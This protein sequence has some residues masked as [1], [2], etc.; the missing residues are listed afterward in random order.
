MGKTA[1][2][3]AFLCHLATNGNAGPFLIIVPTSVLNNWEREMEMWLED[4]ALD[5]ELYHGSQKERG[6]LREDIGRTLRKNKRPLAI[7]TTY[8]V[9]TGTPDDRKFVRKLKPS[10]LVLDEGHNVK[11]SESSRFQH[12]NK[13]S[14]KFRLLLTGTPLQN[15]LQ[16]LM[17]LLAFIMPKQFGDEETMASIQQLFKGDELTME[18]RI[19]RAQRM[20]S[21]FVLRRM[22]RDVLKDLPTKTRETLSVD[23]TN[24]QNKIYE[25]HLI[26]VLRP[27]DQE[28]KMAHNYLM[29]LRKAALHPLLFR[30]LYTTD[31]LA[32]MVKDMMKDGTFASKDPQILFE[33]L[34]A[35]TD[36]ELHSL[37]LNHP[38]N[39]SKYALNE[40]ALYDAGKIPIFIDLVRKHRANGEKLL[41]FSQFVIMLNILQLVL[42]MED[43][44]CLRLD[45]STKGDERQA[46]IDEFNEG[47]DIGVFILSTKA[48]GMGINLST[49]NLVVMFDND[50]NPHNDAQAED[51]GVFYTRKTNAIST[52]CWTNEKCKGCSSGLQKQHRRTNDAHL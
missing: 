33:D 36:F 41:V 8:N 29:A 10:V 3:I 40:E 35:S 46:L 1:T 5:Y 22:K 43:I 9:A 17:S 49:A 38:K 47:D 28:Q 6:G 12:L 21:P 25:E 19:I 26:K 7:I 37:C 51:R 20:M 32:T 18:A 34:E 48:G 16:E 45:G 2:T 30:R 31:T 27:N 52:P 14:S 15:N 39:L 23:M 50:F 4:D 24:T 42:K 44:P 11:N 13:I